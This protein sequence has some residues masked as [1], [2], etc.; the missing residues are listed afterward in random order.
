METQDTNK[1]LLEK[2]K[3]KIKKEI[4]HSRGYAKVISVLRIGLLVILVFVSTLMLS[5][6]ISDII[7]KVRGY[8]FENLPF[9]QNILGFLFEFLIIALLGTLAIYL[10]YRHTDW[11]Y[12]KEKLGLVIG[13]FLIIFLL[14]MGV[15]IL[16]E[17]EKTAVGAFFDGLEEKVEKF[18]P[19]RAWLDSVK[20]IYPLEGT[21]ILIEQDGR[22]SIIE[23]ES[24]SK[25]VRLMLEKRFG[26]FEVGD[27]VRLQ[28]E[29]DGTAQDVEMIEKI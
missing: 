26:E 6:F 5:I 9:T 20:A 2:I 13:S 3:D 29:V 24:E 8:E 17:N 12:V 22:D 4:P 28:Y 18:I 15:I 21:I 7:Q 23:V 16:S 27:K 19:F 14:S 1:E 25:K 10:I 11:P